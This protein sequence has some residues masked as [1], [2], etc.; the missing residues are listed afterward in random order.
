MYKKLDQS[1]LLP[2]VGG[3]FLLYSDNYDQNQTD[4]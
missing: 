1:F 3:N 4:N 2:I